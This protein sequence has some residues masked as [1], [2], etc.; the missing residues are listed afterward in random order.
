MLSGLADA[1]LDAALG[2]HG[3]AELRPCAAYICGQ[4]C[5]GRRE[6]DAKRA[7]SHLRRLY[8]THRISVLKT[9]MPLRRLEDLAKWV[10]GLRKI[11]LPE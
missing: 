5:N 3:T 6:K 7:V 8:P 9:Q 4:L 11:G 2:A 1:E 10:E